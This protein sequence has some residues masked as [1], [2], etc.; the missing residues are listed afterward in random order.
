MTYK[1]LPGQDQ[2]LFGINSKTGDVVTKKTF[3]YEDRSERKV[4]NITIQA[5][6]PDRLA[7]TVGVT[8]TVTDEDEYTPQFLNKSYAFKVPGSAKAGA[9]VG[10]VAA[11]DQDAGAAG[12]LVYSFDHLT[13]Y[14]QI[15]PV[16]GNI[17][18]SHTLHEDIAEESGEPLQMQRRK[19]ALRSDSE[20]LIVSCLLYTSP[21]PRDRLVSRMPSSASSASTARARAARR[22]PPPSWSTA[23][24]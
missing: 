10:R 22:P 20:A 19:R 23:A 15:D 21:S 1:I 17:T 9:F 5:T 4:Y 12:R 13:D 8:I 3:D 11:T 16:S 6:D 14:F 2:E 24:G 7:D 18:V